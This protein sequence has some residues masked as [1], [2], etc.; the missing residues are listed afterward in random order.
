M[1]SRIF[2]AILTACLLVIPSLG[3]A[4]SIPIPATVQPASSDVTFTV[5]LNLTHISADIVTV[6]VICKITSRAIVTGTPGTKPMPYLNG[7]TGLEE[8]ALGVVPTLWKEVD[9]PVAG[10]QLVT[11]ATNVVPV[12]AGSLDNPVGQNALYNCSISGFSKALQGWS[13]F[14]DTPTDVRFR[15]SPTPAEITGPFN[16]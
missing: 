9:F 8:G 3:E 16:W 2:S 14:S 15:L 6:R 10:G 4:Q 12:P 13:H 1:C 5:P 7:A 11:T